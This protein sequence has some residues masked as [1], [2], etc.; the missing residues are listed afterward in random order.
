MERIDK[1]DKRFRN[2]SFIIIII[3]V[4]LLIIWIASY[5]ESPEKASPLL[6]SIGIALLLAGILLF[7]RIQYIIWLKK[8]Y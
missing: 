3:A 7:T 4:L 2:L 5:L 6:L 8:K 1:I